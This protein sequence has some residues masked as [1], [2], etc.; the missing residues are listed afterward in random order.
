MIC[1]MHLIHQDT[2]FCQFPFQNNN[3]FICLELLLGNYGGNIYP[4]LLTVGLEPT[5]SAL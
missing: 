2:T 3:K 4:L 1:C 5:T